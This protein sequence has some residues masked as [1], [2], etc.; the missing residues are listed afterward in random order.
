MR[1]SKLSHEINSRSSN[2]GRVYGSCVTYPTHESCSRVGEVSCHITTEQQC[3][4]LKDNLDSVNSG[5]EVYF[6]STRA[7]GNTKRTVP[8]ILS[9]TNY[10]TVDPLRPLYGRFNPS[11]DFM[12]NGGPCFDLDGTERY[13]NGQSVCFVND[14]PLPNFRRVEYSCETGEYTKGNRNSI[15][16]FKNNDFH[17]F[18][19]DYCLGC[20]RNHD[21]YRE[22]ERSTQEVM[23][24]GEISCATHKDGPQ[25]CHNSIYPPYQQTLFPCEI[26]NEATGAVSSVLRTPDQCREL[27]GKTIYPT[28]PLDESDDRTRNLSLCKN[29]VRQHNPTKLRCMHDRLDQEI[30]CDYLALNLGCI[31]R[32]GCNN[33]FCLNEPCDPSIIGN[34]GEAPPPD[35]NQDWPFVIPEGP[36]GVRNCFPIIEN[37]VR[38]ICDVLASECPS[39]YWSSLCEHVWNP[40]FDNTPDFVPDFPK[41]PEDCDMIRPSRN[42]DGTVNTSIDPAP[43][44]NLPRAYAAMGSSGLFRQTTLYPIGDKRTGGMI[45]KSNGCVYINDL[46][47][48]FASNGQIQN[49][50]YVYTPDIFNK[51]RMGSV[52]F[53]SISEA[54]NHFIEMYEVGGHGI[55]RPLSIDEMYSAHNGTAKHLTK[56]DITQ[57]VVTYEIEKTFNGLII[58]DTTGSISDYDGGEVLRGLQIRTVNIDFP[59]SSSPIKKS[60]TLK[61]NIVAGTEKIV[62]RALNGVAVGGSS[63]VS[64]FRRRETLSRRPDLTYQYINPILGS[65][66]EESNTCFLPDGRTI[67]TTAENC[68]LLNGTVGDN[69]DEFYRDNQ[70]VKE[71]NG[72]FAYAE[73]PRPENYGQVQNIEYSPKIAATLYES[74]RD[75]KYDSCAESTTTFD[76]CTLCVEQDHTN[77]CEE[78]KAKHECW[79]KFKNVKT[80][81]V[82][83]TPEFKSPFC[84]EMRFYCKELAPYDICSR[85]VSGSAIVEYQNAYQNQNVNSINTQQ[86]PPQFWEPG[87]PDGKYNYINTCCPQACMTCIFDAMRAAESGD[88]EA[89]TAGG[90][91]D[92]G[93]TYGDPAGS[94]PDKNLRGCNAVNKCDARNCCGSTGPLPTNTKSRCW[95]CGPYQIK[96]KYFDDAAEKYKNQHPACRALRN[97]DWEDEMCKGCTGSLENIRSCCKRKHDIS[98]LVIKCYLRRYT[99]NGDCQ[100]GNCPCQTINSDGKQFTCEDIV[101]MHNGGAGKPKGVPCAQ[102][103]NATVAYWDKIQRALC[104]LGGSCRRCIEFDYS[105]C[106]NITSLNFNCLFDDDPSRRGMQGRIKGVPV[107]TNTNTVPKDLKLGGNVG[108]FSFKGTDVNSGKSG[109]FYPLY[110]TPDA[111]RKQNPDAMGGEYYHTHSFKELPN[112][113]FFM[114]NNQNNHGVSTNGGFLEFKDDRQ[115]VPTFF[116][117]NK[118]DQLYI[119]YVDPLDDVKKIQRRTSY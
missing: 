35:G 80:A 63:T 113:T 100:K 2:A 55:N 22:F 103:R 43:N 108:P 47:G 41:A 30:K 46:K 50:V 59:L 97:L 106:N 11:I 94:Y 57:M 10:A 56:S 38:R 1:Y 49:T 81:G 39:C 40:L 89:P 119:P 14:E 96:K 99:R 88:P 110:L 52:Q 101:R 66:V 87:L 76:D 90:P 16:F 12:S 92:A 26:V 5:F 37:E 7:C 69:L 19:S 20:E 98:Q 3:N 114:P 85:G 65:I 75:K 53:K 36:D 68:T 117:K 8:E 28:P 83:K 93:R 70:R 111:A 48:Y 109:Y 67:F 21:V 17:E 15:K 34:T 42:P 44:P 84:E 25:Q 27:G 107:F 95:S 73:R 104:N 4:D 32:F 72:L 23:P 105:D 86:L 79:K 61:I 29:C 51:L 91:N 64:P 13:E 62:A 115:R 82:K 9:S 18:P 60:D 112:Y 77:M 6:D 45:C 118:P 74:D 102:N 116:S 58:N 24:Y 71:S 33:P 78:S 31:S 54:R